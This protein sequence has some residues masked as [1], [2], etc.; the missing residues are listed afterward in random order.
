MATRMT[1]TSDIVIGMTDQTEYVA[2]VF[3]EMAGEYDHLKDPWYSYTFSEIER[4]LRRHFRLSTVGQLK[5]LAL[6]IGCGTGIQ[7]LVLAQLGY[8]VEGIDIADDLIEIARAKLQHAAF[9]DTHFQHAD[10]TKLPFDDGIAD[11]VNCCGPTLSFVPEWRT[12]LREI[13]R[14]LRPGGKLLLEVEGKWTLDMLWEVVN[15]LAGNRLDYDKSL[16]N[17]LKQFLPPWNVGRC[18]EYSFV[19]ES[20]ETVKMPL[21]LFTAREL[22]RELRQVG[23]VVE[24]RWGLHFLTNIFPST[25]LHR[26]DASPRVWSLFRKLAGVERFL[27]SL[28]PFNALACSLL[29]VAVKED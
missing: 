20:G 21:R 17:A 10:A 23:L 22:S 27:Y 28:W 13:S 1:D 18:I 4:V 24:R 16:M 26:A 12:A 25:V 14:C 29:V 15:A 9:P 11:A 8:R 2:R 19:L 3:N 7:S 6:D 5:P